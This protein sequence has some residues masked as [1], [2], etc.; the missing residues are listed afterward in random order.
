MRILI[1]NTAVLNTGDAAILFATMKILEQSFDKPLEFIVYDQQAETAKRY[2][3]ELNFRPVI[4]DQLTQEL[5]SGRRKLDAARLMVAAILRRSPL[6]AFAQWLA[7]A[8]MRQSLEEFAGADLIVSAGG[9]YLVPH[10]RILPK[11]LDLLI[12][13]AVRRPIV[14]FTQSLGPFPGPRRSLLHFVL[15][16]ARAILV[17][18]AR[19]YRHLLDFGIRPDRIAEFADAAFA[20]AEPEVVKQTVNK[21]TAA[22]DET[23]L[24]LAISVRDWP[25]IG[26]DG[27]EGMARYLGAVADTVRWLVEDRDVDVTFLST[28]QGIEEYWTDDSRVAE[29]VVALLPIHIRERVWIDREFH[30]PGALIAL[31]STFDMI[32]ATRMH[33][34]IMA[35]GAGVPVLPIAY[36]FKTVELFKRLGLGH[37]VQDIETVTGEGLIGAAR[38]LLDRRRD[39]SAKLVACIERER[40]SA[41]SAGRYIREA[42]GLA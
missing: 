36:E 15:R 33:V 4:Y 11:L 35:L 32:V 24:R 41:F 3:P 1:T 18:D 9:T 29:S 31:L 2:Y 25:H 12:A 5:R 23:K 20:L 42:V 17:R 10:Y 34:A 30:D 39:V 22:A 7:P 21:C 14:L 37:L 27:A 38:S 13:R 8:N 26:G 28:C 6:R 19:S 40:C 16:S